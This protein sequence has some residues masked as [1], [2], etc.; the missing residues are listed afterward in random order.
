VGPIRP[1]F[2][3]YRNSDAS[4]AALLFCWLASMI[5]PFFPLMSLPGW[6]HKLSAF[7]HG[8][9]LSPVPLVSAAASWVAIAFMIR[10]TRIRRVRLWL[11]LSLFLIPAQFAIITRQP[12]P[13]DL[14]GAAA[15]IALFIFADGIPSAIAVA[16]WAFVGVLAIRGLAPFH[17]SSHGQPFSWVPFGGFLTT[18]WQYGIQLVLQKTFYYGAAIWM[19]RRAAM[20]WL[21]AI[22]IVCAVL[23]GIEILQMHIP[24]RTSEITDPVLALLTGL[25]LRVLERPVRAVGYHANS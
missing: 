9:V 25:G 13:V 3:G 24:G 19:L 5:F 22:C 7:V 15:G 16:A 12:L 6:R 8:S 20:N 21:P 17:W 14:L 10:A 23:T 18:E 1:G 11:L 4:A 2:A